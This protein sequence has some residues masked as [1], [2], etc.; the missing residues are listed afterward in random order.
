MAVWR[1][2]WTVSSTLLP[3]N[4]IV[5]VD[6]SGFDRSH[7]SKHYT[8][9]VDLLDGLGVRSDRGTELLVAPHI[10]FVTGEGENRG[11]VS[12]GRH[13]SLSLSTVVDRDWL[14]VGGR[15]GGRVEFAPHVLIVVVRIQRGVEAV[16]GGEIADEMG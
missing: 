12:G 10:E 5:G 6:A 8:K 4:G 15:H 3:T 7:A 13:R 9:R 14:V 1:I 2:L 11:G 16:V